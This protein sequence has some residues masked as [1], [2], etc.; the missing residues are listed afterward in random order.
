MLGRWCQCSTNTKLR[1]TLCKTKDRSLI[2]S[3]VQYT[4]T[5]RDWSCGNIAV[6]KLYH[7]KAW[8]NIFPH[9]LPNSSMHEM[10]VP[11]ADLSNNSYY[12]RFFELNWLDPWME[13]KNTV[14]SND[15]LTHFLKFKNHYTLSMQTGMPSLGP[16][17]AFNS[18]PNRFNY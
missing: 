10:L 5:L 12:L 18:S 17:R 15:Q 2:Q 11:R 8:A 14:S 4:L 3:Y 1:R 16:I 9:L 13:M 6:H 7:P